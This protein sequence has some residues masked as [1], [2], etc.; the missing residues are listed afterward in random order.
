MQN[1]GK[2]FLADL[3]ILNVNDKKYFN[4]TDSLSLISSLKPK[5][6]T[7]IHQHNI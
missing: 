4:Y 3:S 5:K 7:P 2:L 1:N 6:S